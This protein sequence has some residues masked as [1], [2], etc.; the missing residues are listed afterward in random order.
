M[1]PDR[2]RA[3]GSVPAERWFL[4]AMLAGS[5]ALACSRG[6]IPIV[7]GGPLLPSTLTAAAAVTR[8]PLYQFTPGPG[9]QFPHAVFG[10]PAGETLTVRQVAGV[11]GSDVGHLPHNARGLSL[12]GN[13]TSLGSSVWVEIV[14][15]EGGTG[16]VPAVQI[17]QDV[18]PEAFC[19]DARIPALL[20]AL[21]A[22]IAARDAAGLRALVSPRRALTVR[23]DWWNPEVT[24][25]ADAL[26]DAFGSDDA[27]TWG[28]LPSGAAITGTFKGVVLP[29][30]DRVAGDDVSYTCNQIVIGS[31]LREARWPSEYVNLNFYSLHRPAGP[32]ESEFAWS[33][34]LVGVE[35]VDNQPYISHLVQ[36]RAGV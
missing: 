11:A 33:T 35:Y 32:T 9:F 18:P 30:L 20:D 21:R 36:L 23:L 5:A 1:S 12:T 17:T 22:S 16:W 4:A 28:Q 31:S 3:P 29:L 24:L 8:T 14:R 15:P 6:T 34:W 7:P 13:A 10:V 26:A 25:R 19:G 27:G 2:R